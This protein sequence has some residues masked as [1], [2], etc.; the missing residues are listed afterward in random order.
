[1]IL[2]SCS[3]QCDINHGRERKGRN[4]N[5]STAEYD[6]YENRGKLETCIIQNADFNN[7]GQGKADGGG[8]RL[9]KFCLPW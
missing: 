7:G 6:K 3:S 4:S 8:R 5:S 2:F 9:V 1:M